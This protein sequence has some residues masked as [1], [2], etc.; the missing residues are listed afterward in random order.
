MSLQSLYKTHA[1]GD[2]MIFI[3]LGIKRIPLCLEQEWCCE[4]HQLNWD[5]IF[6][7]FLCDI[8]YQTYTNDQMT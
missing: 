2:I 6:Y 8:I 1:Q 4:Q 5:Y 7:V 3:D